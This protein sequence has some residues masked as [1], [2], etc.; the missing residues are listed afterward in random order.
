M[1]TRDQHHWTPEEDA[2]LTIIWKEGKLSTAAMGAEFGVSKN[3]LVGRAHRI[4][5]ARASPIKP[6]QAGQQPKNPVI[7]RYTKKSNTPAPGMPH[8][9][10][11]PPEPQTIFKPRASTECSWVTE[12]IRPGQRTKWH[13]CDEPTVPGKSYC[14]AHCELAY[15][16][17]SPRRK[18]AA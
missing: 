5:L 8:T 4:G 6:L 17:Y 2:R 14:G 7:P 15:V 16:P 3:S 18:D 9:D 11:P 12:T 10:L 1:A 13:Y